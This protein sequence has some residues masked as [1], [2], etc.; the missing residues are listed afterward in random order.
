MI[1]KNIKKLLT[2]EKFDDKISFNS[3]GMVPKLIDRRAQDV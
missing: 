1:N 3:L 2:L